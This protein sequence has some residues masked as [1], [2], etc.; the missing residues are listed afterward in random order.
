MRPPTRRRYAT[1]AALS[2]VLSFGLLVSGCGGDST[3]ATA[4]DGEVYLLPVDAQGPDP[5]TASSAR[6]LSAPAPAPPS[7]DASRPPSRGQTLRTLSGATPGLYGGTQSVGSCDVERQVGFLAG[8]KAKARAF[9]QGAGIQEAGIPGFL[10]GLT[11]VVL[12]AD[13]RMTNHG[14]RGGS[15]VAYQTVLQAGTAVMVDQ[16]GAPRVRCACGNPLKPPVAVKGAVIH[17]GTPWTGYRPDRVVVIKPTTTVLTSLVI[18][19]IV[20]NTW[21]E[22]KTG[23]DG[24]EDKRPDVL[25]PVNPDDIYSYPPVLPPDS[26]DPS[27][28]NGDQPRSEQPSATDCPTLTAPAPGDDPSTLPPVP[29]GCPAS[30]PLDPAVPP[31]DPPSE[32]Q[33]PPVPDVP[34]DGAVP[35]D[36]DLLIPSEQP[37][38]PDTFPG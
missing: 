5:H 16:Y 32:V 37:A 29:P 19:N 34:S 20:N 9:A 23:S 2:A 36:P 13:T 33:P 24:E 28:P 1:A 12:R 17:K 10:R 7:A 14:Y 11:P 35:T 26:T 18:V 4:A 38:E 6:S 8:D 3:A 21:I 15:S 30:P 31:A 25:P 22:R 27:S